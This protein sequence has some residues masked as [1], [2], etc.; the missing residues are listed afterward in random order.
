MSRLSE[1]SHGSWY[2]H[3]SATNLLGRRERARRGGYPS[4]AAARSARDDFLASSAANRT[5]DGP[6][7]NAHWRGEPS[8]R[9][10]EGSGL[11]ALQH[12]HV[13]KAMSCG[14]RR[15]AALRFPL[16]GRGIPFCG[17]VVNRW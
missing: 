16:S 1:R 17:T 15:V 14:N 6:E 9:K 11:R 10:S 4:Q 8:D 12:T 5:A 2:F 13:T 3:C 7:G